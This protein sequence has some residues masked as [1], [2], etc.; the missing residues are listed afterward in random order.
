MIVR[1]FAA[2][3]GDD[4][5]VMP[6]GLVRFAAAA[7]ERVVSMQRG[8]GSKDL[9]VLSNEP[10]NQYSLL[11]G[12]SGRIELIR[13]GGDLPSRVADNLFWLGRYTERAEAVVRLL[14]GILGRLVEQAGIEPGP[15]MPYLLRTATHVTRSYPGFATD[16]PAAILPAPET[17]MLALIFDETKPGSLRSVLAAARHAAN[18]VRDR[19]SQDT[20]HI[21]FSLGEELADPANT[22]VGAAIVLLNRLVARLSAFSG[23]VMESMT[24]GLAW[25]FLDMGRKL[26]RSIQ[27]ANLLRSTLVNPAAEETP[28]L[29]AVLE[30]ADSIMTY[31]RRYMASLQ[32]H[33]VLDLLLTDE[34]NPRSV[35]F[36]IAAL[37]QHVQLLPGDRATPTWRA[38][39]KMAESL[40]SSLRLAAVDDLCRTDRQGMRPQLDELLDRLFIELPALS[41][42]MS[43]NYLSHTITS[44]QLA[45]G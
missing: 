21:I 26:E 19:L 44:R 8:G 5:N 32:P 16:D 38:E 10:V 23:L 29:E 39:Q 24:R 7:Q 3:S 43:H 15:E 14:R 35:A 25:T 12:Q 4:F 34:T 36:G 30:I 40:L 13:G 6:G 1:A 42:T 22:D 20:W 17:E 31:R 27:T 9:W 11:P 28:L 37:S 2:A 18:A 45:E 33:A 41:E